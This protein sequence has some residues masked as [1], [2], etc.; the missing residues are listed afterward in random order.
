MPW[1]NAGK[2]VAIEPNESRSYSYFE[3]VTD[4]AGVEERNHWVVKA[5]KKMKMYHVRTL[6]QSFVIS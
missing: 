1:I 2:V 5:L 6:P 4:R 3:P